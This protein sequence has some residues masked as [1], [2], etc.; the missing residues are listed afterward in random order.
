[1]LGQIEKK[2]ITELKIHCKIVNCLKKIV[3]SSN[4]LLKIELGNN[5]EINTSQIKKNTSV[6]NLEAVFNEKIVFF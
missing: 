3:E 6:A 2:N 1:M 4:V 5:D